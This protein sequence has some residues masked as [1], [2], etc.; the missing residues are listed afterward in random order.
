MYTLADTTCKQGAVRLAGGHSV[1][2]GRVQVCFQKEWHSVC[3]DGWDDIKAMA[4]RVCT[5]LGYSAELGQGRW[6]SWYC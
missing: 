6:P 3:S 2:E 5:R 4:N 1:K